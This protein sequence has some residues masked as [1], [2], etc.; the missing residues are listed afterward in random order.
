MFDDVSLYSHDVRRCNVVFSFTKSYAVYVN[1]CIKVKVVGGI[2]SCND[3][4]LKSLKIHLPFLSFFC[5]GIEIDSFKEV[6]CWPIYYR[7]EVCREVNLSLVLRARN[8]LHD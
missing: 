5:A 2:S 6:I 8:I 1:A 7:L 4:R 3:R